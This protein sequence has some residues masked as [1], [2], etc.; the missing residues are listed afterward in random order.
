MKE[1]PLSSRREMT[2]GRQPEARHFDET[3]A[4]RYPLAAFALL[5]G[6]DLFDRE[7]PPVAQLSGLELA[8]QAVAKTVH[9]EVGREL[10]QSVG[11][12]RAEVTRQLA[13]NPELSQRFMLTKPIRVD[14]VR[15]RQDMVAMG[16][17]RRVS[18]TASGVFWDQPKWGAARIAFRLDR[19][20]LTQERTLVFHEFAHA[21][22][23]LAMSSKERELITQV[24]RPV[25]GH[26]ADQDEV[27]AI[28]SEREFLGVEA[29][30]KLE[31]AAPGVYGWCRRQWNEDHIFAAFV[32]KLY[33]PLQ[34]IRAGDRDRAAGRRWKSFLGE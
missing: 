8:A 17:P 29:F 2:D 12:V 5:R 18:Q 31:Q 20:E 19:L 3:L 27:F 7:T 9:F 6:G 11:R 21:I 24:L 16:Y 14:L 10:E 15:S 32:K 22:H 30:S 34:R 13:G 1:L 23:H 4:L 28:Y 26:P 25:F 33:H